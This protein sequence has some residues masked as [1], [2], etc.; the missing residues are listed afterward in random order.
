[1]VGGPCCHDDDGDGKSG[2]VF[3]R[4]HTPPHNLTHLRVNARSMCYFFE[5]ITY[6]KDRDL[7]SLRLHSAMLSGLCRFT[8]V[9]VLL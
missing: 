5:P 2:S 8:E 9:L 6:N 1:M 4:N 7:F 3:C